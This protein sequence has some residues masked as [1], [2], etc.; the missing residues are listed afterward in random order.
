MYVSGFSNSSSVMNWNPPGL[1]ALYWV[2]VNVIS[3]STICRCS[4]PVNFCLPIAFSIMSTKRLVVSAQTAVS[5]SCM[6][7]LKP[8][9]SSLHEFFI[10]R[11][12]F[13]L[14]R[15][16]S[17]SFNSTIALLHFSRSLGFQCLRYF[18]AVIILS[19]LVFM[20][21]GPIPAFFVIIR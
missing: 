2:I 5:T 1:T 18:K 16:L 11:T 19:T 4:S 12:L 15:G 7:R 20:P 3:V 8:Q 21:S 9:S 6:V 17:H 14:T 13:F 10:L